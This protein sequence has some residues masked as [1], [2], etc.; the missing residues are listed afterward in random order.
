MLCISLWRAFL[1]GCC[2]CSIAP[3]SRRRST[4][5]NSAD[6]CREQNWQW[7]KLAFFVATSSFEI[8]GF[9]PPQATVAR[10]MVQIKMF[11]GRWAKL[12]ERASGMESASPWPVTSR[13]PS[14]ACRKRWGFAVGPPP[15]TACSKTRSRSRRSLLP[16]PPPTNN[17]SSQFSTDLLPTRF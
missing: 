16:F 15:A 11:H 7:F 2:G 6:G 5:G 10:E 12:N 3:V 8:L 14:I 13:F 1:A 9:F 17:R 4:L